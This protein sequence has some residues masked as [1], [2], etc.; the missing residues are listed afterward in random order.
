MTPS[1][2]QPFF[3]CMV[4]L[5]S[6]TVASCGSTRRF[7]FFRYGWRYQ[8]GPWVR[9]GCRVVVPDM[10]GYGGSDKPVDP[11][12]YSTKKLC[13]DL[14]AL[15]DLLDVK[16]AVGIAYDSSY[17]GSK[18]NLQLADTC[19]PR[20]GGIHRRALRFV[21]S[22]THISTGDVRILKLLTC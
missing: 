13:S 12:E 22:R 3:A 4:S 21:V 9:K 11:S 17:H 15:L 18:F 14:V 6:G 20:L 1:A 16:K 2:R 8:I 19:W 10:L 5:I 7:T